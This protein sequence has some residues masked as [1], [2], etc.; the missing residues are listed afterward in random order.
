M[1]KNKKFSIL[2]IILLFVSGISLKVNAESNDINSDKTFNH[3]RNILK[4]NNLDISDLFRSVIY[5]D[6]DGVEKSTETYFLLNNEI[7]VDD[8][9]DTGI[10][11]NDIRV[12]YLILPWIEFGTDLSI[13]L[14][15]LF[16]VERIGDE[17]KNSDF[18]LSASIG[19]E[20]LSIGYST[21]DNIGNEIPK[22]ISFSILLFVNTVE[23]GSGLKFGMDP[24]YES[25]IEDKELVLFG[26]NYDSDTDIQREYFFTFNPPSK[27]EITISS[28]RINGEWH[29]EFIRENN[30]AVDCS[31]QILEY[32][33]SDIRDT[34][35]KFFSL[36]SNLNFNLMITPFTTDGGFF[37]YQS[38]TMYN[39]KIQIQSNNLGLCEYVIIDNI[40]RTLEA[41]WLPIRNNGYYHLEIDSDGTDI[42]L[43][44]SL[45]DPTINLSLSGLSDIDMTAYWNFSNPGDFR[46][47]K[48]PSL[49]LDISVIIGDWEFLLDAQPIAEDI[50]VSWLTDITGY[51]TYDTNSE[52]LNQM[53]LLVKGSDIGIRTVADVF[54]ADDFR[55]DWTIWP[56]LEWNIEKTGYIDHISLL[57]EV[58]IEG[59]WYKIW[60][61]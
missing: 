41:E 8:N 17:I 46:I 10:N 19:G 12:Q 58:Y 43:L 59:N 25:S 26:K 15:F 21:P 39:T 53:D 44:D 4:L 24:T 6:I 50:F 32:E 1:K 29:Y 49:K 56:P 61:W 35:I 9:L 57:I 27:S 22:T 42:R 11:G 54:K 31:W 40:P 60:P 13:G 55:L 36:P 2:I 20:T 28:T 7:N 37:S 33:N 48:E 52:P 38:E 5:T 45:I 51:L 14:E 18:Y 47:I 34:T 23:G 30:Y 3:G 16:L